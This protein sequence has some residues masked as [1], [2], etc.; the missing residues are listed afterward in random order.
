[1]NIQQQ[2][3][4]DEQHRQC[5]DELRR[6][7]FQVQRCQQEPDKNVSFISYLFR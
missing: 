6:I 3:E 4:D 2:K 7:F 1:M 5:I